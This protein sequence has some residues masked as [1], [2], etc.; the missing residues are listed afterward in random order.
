M[1]TLQGQ[2]KGKKYIIKYI[3]QCEGIWHDAI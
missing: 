3:T 1:E 2:F